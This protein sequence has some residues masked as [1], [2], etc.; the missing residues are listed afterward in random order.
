MY[1][2][3]NKKASR[4]QLHSKP[5][6]SPHTEYKPAYRAY[7]NLNIQTA[8]YM[9]TYVSVRKSINNQGNNIYTYK[10]I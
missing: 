6:S 3:F 7:T 8:Y 9:L 1:T 4:C 2:A 5:E 10:L